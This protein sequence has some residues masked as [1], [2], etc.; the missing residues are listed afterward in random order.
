LA[1]LPT[2]RQRLRGGKGGQQGYVG[3]TATNWLSGDRLR[4]VAG[5]PTRSSSVSPGFKIAAAHGQFDIT[6]FKSNRHRKKESY[7][8]TLFSFR[9]SLLVTCQLLIRRVLSCGHGN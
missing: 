2:R 1:S 5:V 8:K 3:A 4:L 7:G 9:I 6:A